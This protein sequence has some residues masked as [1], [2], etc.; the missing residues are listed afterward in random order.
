[1]SNPTMRLIRAELTLMRRDPLVLTFVVAFP[2]VTMLIIGGAFGSTPDRAFDF[3]NPA[4][5]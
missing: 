3:T 1:M 2:I 4:H 5:W